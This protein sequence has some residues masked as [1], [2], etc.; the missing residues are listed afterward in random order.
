M[1]LLNPWLFF[2]GTRTL[3]NTIEAGMTS[4][5]LACWPWSLLSSTSSPTARARELH[6]LRWAILL[7][8]TAVLLRPTNALIWAVLTLWTLWSASRNEMISFMRTASTYGIAVLSISIGLDHRYYGRLVFPPIE[9]LRYNLQQNLA[10]FYG[11]NRAD[12]YFTEGL[13]LLL[14]SFLPFALLGLYRALAGTSIHRAILRPLSLTTLSSILALSSIAHKEVRFLAPLL[15]PL[16]L[17][18]AA[19]LATYLVPPSPPSRLKRLLIWTVAALEIA[20]ALFASIAHQRGPLALTSHLRALHETRNRAFFAGATHA[21]EHPTTV[22]LL[23]PCHSTPWRSHLYYR[24]VHAWALTCEPPLGLSAAGRARYVDEADVFY[25]D[26]VAWLVAA[27]RAWPQHLG[28]F[29]SLVA[30][31]AGGRSGA[32]VRAALSGL[33]YGECWRGFGSWVHEDWRRRGDVVVWCREEEGD[34]D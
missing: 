28:M 13:P 17:L 2:T 14:T 10:V 1:T 25:G 11:T 7:A 21:V 15:A 32:E 29:E 23:M 8:A 31:G 33:G 30:R 4:I 24:G 6:S 20:L 16:H 22:G 9:F 12:Y 18:A 27:P 3:S 19:P 26:P 5:A 34:V